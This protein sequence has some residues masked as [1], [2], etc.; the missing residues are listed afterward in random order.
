MTAELPSIVDVLAAS[1][2]L[3]TASYGLVDACKAFN[4]GIS[5]VGF[6][7][8]RNAI[9]PLFGSAGQFG[10][11]DAMDTLR[12][13]WLNGMATAQQKAVAKA[14]IR[15][16]LTPANAKD[17]A[18]ATGLP[19]T[20]LQKIAETIEKGGDL[21]PYINQLGRFDAVIGAILDAAYERGEQRYRNA[22]KLAAGAVSVAIAVVAGP[23]AFSM[24][25]ADY[26]NFSPQLLE[27]FLIGLVSTPLAPIAKDLTSTLQAAVKAVSLAKR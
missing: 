16:C 19:E 25:A 26:W 24:S 7:D 23:I 22:A 21:A 9:R 17:L 1:G 20:D 18:K 6:A 12:A 2:A 27:A 11:H 10:V 13:N 5:N 15:M 3:G 8:V 4:G 14:L